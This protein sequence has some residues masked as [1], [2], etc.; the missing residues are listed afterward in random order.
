MFERRIN[1]IP[2]VDHDER[3]VG[4]ISRADIVQMIALEEARYLAEA[5]AAPE[6]ENTSG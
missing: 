1:A 3:L 2:V 5:Q 4:V 6:P